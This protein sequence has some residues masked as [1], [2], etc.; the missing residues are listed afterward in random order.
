MAEK[1]PESPPFILYI[2]KPEEL[3]DPMLSNL[4]HLLRLKHDLFDVLNDVGLKLLNR[5]IFATYADCIDSGQRDAANA[6]IDSIL[7]E[8]MDKKGNYKRRNSSE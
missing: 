7:P 3:A 8:S 6:L 2:L 1:E 5:L 4:G